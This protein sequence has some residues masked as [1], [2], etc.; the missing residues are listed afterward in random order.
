MK[1]AHV[2]RTAINMAWMAERRA[3]VVPRKGM[4]VVGKGV[5]TSGEAL[6]FISF[7]AFIALAEYCPALNH[8]TEIP[9]RMINDLGRGLTRVGKEIEK[10]G[11]QD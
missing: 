1:N 3:R 11:R 9:L 10:C 7:F 2:L 4:E 8:L 6:D 5:K